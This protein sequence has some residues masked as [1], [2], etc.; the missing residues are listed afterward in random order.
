MEKKSEG[1]PVE[2]RDE[3]YK[4]SIFTIPNVICFGRLIGSFVLFGFA[5]AGWRY[6]FV[7]LFL[8]LS[9]SDWIDGRLARWLHQRSDF[10]ARLDSTADAVLYTALLG[11]AAILSWNWIQQELVWLAVGVG[12]YAVT[13][14]VGLSKY[15]R[16]PS[17]HTYGAKITQWI[18]LV[19]G[20]CLVL[21]WSVWP[22]RI[23]VI[24]VT[25]T[26]IEATAI[27]CVLKEWQAD[28]LTILHV[29]PRANQDAEEI[30]DGE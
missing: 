28:V 29:W 18:A 1:R 11:G 13:T 27:T 2:P 16:V 22:L 26:N 8:V 5:L 23:A 12:S 20:V 14:G 17:Y 7:G 21:H 24:A 19:A 9:F 6:W 30:P 3:M 15:G 25:L 4:D 10:G